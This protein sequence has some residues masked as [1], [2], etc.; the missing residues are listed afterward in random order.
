[1]YVYAHAFYL[2][3]CIYN[4]YTVSIFDISFCQCIDNG[5]GVEMAGMSLDWNS[6][7][8]DRDKLGLKCQ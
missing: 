8:M 3:I 1:M 7:E 2:S 5:V 4:M 6:K